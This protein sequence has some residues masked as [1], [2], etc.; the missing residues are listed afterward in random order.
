[1]VDNKITEREVYAY[2]LDTFQ[3]IYGD[4]VAVL[5]E[6]PTQIIFQLEAA[7]VH[8]AVASRN[9]EDQHENCQRA[10]V[11]LQR[12]SLDAVKILWLVKKKQLSGIIEDE[13]VRQFCVNTA[14][15]ELLKLY[16]TAEHLA[17]EARQI[18]ISSVGIVRMPQ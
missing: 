11:H 3:P 10:L 17:K 4:L 18:E 9:S 1:V 7:L 16:R 14:E 8:L 15:S 12:A 13:D 5:G 6:K 2:L